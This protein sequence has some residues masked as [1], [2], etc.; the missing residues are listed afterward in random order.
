ML[1]LRVVE[2]PKEIFLLIEVEAP[3]LWHIIE[4]AKLL[5][6]ARMC[7]NDLAFGSEIKIKFWIKRL[8]PDLQGKT[9][10][11]NTVKLPSINQ[12]DCNRKLFSLI[13][14]VIIMVFL[15]QRRRECRSLVLPKDDGLLRYEHDG[16]DERDDTDARAS[17]WPVPLTTLIVV[18]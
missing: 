18:E 7:F 15:D 1:N 2:A 8:K 13:G 14:K 11:R 17:K 12:S 4:L 3:W 5:F 16:D 6:W 10:F 9:L